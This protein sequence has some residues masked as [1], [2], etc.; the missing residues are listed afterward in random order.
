MNPKM[1]NIDLLEVNQPIVN[2]NMLR[3]SSRSGGGS[4]EDGSEP[5][6]SHSIRG[7]NDSFEGGERIN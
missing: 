5:S 7:T 3:D 6:S 2:I 4:V 1:S